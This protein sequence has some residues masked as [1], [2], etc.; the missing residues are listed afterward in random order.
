[1]WNSPNRPTEEGKRYQVADITALTLPLDEILDQL[2][3]LPVREVIDEPILQQLEKKEFIYA[4][5]QVFAALLEEV[6]VP[7]EGHLG[8]HEAIIAELLH[9][10]YSLICCELDDPEMVGSARKAA[11]QTINRLLVNRTSDGMELPFALEE[12][13]INV[14]S[15]KAYLSKKLT[16]EVWEELLLD[17][18]GLW[19]EFLWDDDWRMGSLLDLPADGAESVAHVAGID[20]ETVHKLAHTPS[21]AEFKMAD[22][23]IRHI[24]REGEVPGAK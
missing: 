6:Q 12:L 22:S 8:I 5:Y 7:P 24:I 16:A 2:E 1:M 10:T 15:P 23:Y 14:T 20:L 17:E 19:S 18:G 11:W 4:L 13:N 3:Y 21:E 9:Q